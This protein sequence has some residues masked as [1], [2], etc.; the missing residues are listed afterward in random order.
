[1]NHMGQKAK[2]CHHSGS[3]SF[4]VLL[5]ITNLF[6]KGNHYL[7]F[8]YHRVSFELLLNENIYY[9]FFYICLLLLHIIVVRFIHLMPVAVVGWASLLCS[10]PLVDYITIYP[11]YYWTSRLFSFSCCESGAMNILVHMFWW[12]WWTIE[13][14]CIYL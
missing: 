1:M 12:N 5:T 4:F 7:Y 8:Y 2:H 10:I 13:Y 3:L 14:A 6:C 11:S 9:I